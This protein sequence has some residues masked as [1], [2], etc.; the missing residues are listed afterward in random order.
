MRLSGLSPSPFGISASPLKRSQPFLSCFKFESRPPPALQSISESDF[1]RRRITLLLLPPRFLFRCIFFSR[2]FA[3]S[4]FTEF[5]DHSHA[6]PDA[7]ST[8]TF[9]SAVNPYNTLL[10][11]F[12]SGLPFPCRD[13]VPTITLA[14]P[15]FGEPLSLLQRILLPHPVQRRR[16]PPTINV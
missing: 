11:L 8:F 16:F 10:S 5:F 14:Q 15:L 12:S 2:T 13:K 4:L 7:G 1:L 9:S 3:A 6:A